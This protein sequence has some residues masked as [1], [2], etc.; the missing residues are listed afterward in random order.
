MLKPFITSINLEAL[1]NRL[2]EL[3]DGYANKEDYKT[4]MTFIAA[5]ALIIEHQTYPD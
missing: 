2:K 1:K 3:A 5:L 4:A